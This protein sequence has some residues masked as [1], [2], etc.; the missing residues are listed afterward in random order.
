MQENKKVPTKIEVEKY[1]N[2]YKSDEPVIREYVVG[3]LALAAEFSINPDM[4]KKIVSLL[5]IASDDEDSRIRELAQK[6]LKEFDVLEF[7]KNR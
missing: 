3:K 1:I 6:A 7:H 4:N 2:E 5:E